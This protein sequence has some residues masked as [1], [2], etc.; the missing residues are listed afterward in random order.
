MMDPKTMAQTLTIQYGYTTYLFGATPTGLTNE[1]ALKQPSPGGNCLNWVA[2]HIVQARG[3]T[4]A[5]LGQEL[6]FSA[7]EDGLAAGLA[8]MTAEGLAE[9]APFSPGNNEKETVESLVAGLV[10]HEGYHIGQ[11]GLL[12]R[13]AGEEGVV[14]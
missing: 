14:K 10:F 11:L 12:R 3:A 1:Q 9:K 6:P 4:L 5:V 2:G 7:T 13:L 8:S